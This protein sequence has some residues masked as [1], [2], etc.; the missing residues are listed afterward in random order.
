MEARDPRQPRIAVVT[1]ANRGIGQAIAQGLDARGFHVMSA[2][3][4]P[5]D[6]EASFGETVALDVTEPQSV[7]ALASELRK[8]GGANVLVNNAGVS[9]DGF[10]ETVAARTLE[11]NFFGAMRVTDALVPSM[12]DRA[13]IVMVSSG[14]GTL[15]H[16]RGDLRQRFEDPELTRDALVE[17]MQS[18]V[19]DVASGVH[20]RHGWP[21]SAYSVSKVGLNALV[22]VMAREL[23][24]DPRRILI[25]AA[26]PGWVRTRM[27]GSSAPRS[28]EEGARTPVWLAELPESGPSGGFFRDQRAVAF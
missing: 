4:S 10:D 13:R 11:T 2:A 16:I 19:R 20:A 5:R 25:N 14:L 23:A 26:D 28:V 1:G 15:S 9:L 22:R 8:R 21:S 7:A 18:F 24:G 27:G 6:A 12:Q 3:R 17:L